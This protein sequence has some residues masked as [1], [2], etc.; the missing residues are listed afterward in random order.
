MRVGVRVRVYLRLG[1]GALEGGQVELPQ[2]ALVDAG[3]D[4][5]PEGLLLRVRIRVRVGVRVSYLPLG[6]G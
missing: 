1:D 6:L 2:R 4:H 3:V 5:H